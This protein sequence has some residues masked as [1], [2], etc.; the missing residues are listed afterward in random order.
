MYRDLKWKIP[1]ILA[2]VL[3]SV[4]L[5]YPLKEKISLGLDLQ[6]GMHLL[7][8]VTCDVP[9]RSDLRTLYSQDGRDHNYAVPLSQPAGHPRANPRANPRA[10]R[11][12]PA[13]HPRARK[14]TDIR[15]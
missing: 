15:L 9:L 11:G 6:G 8:E 4:L 3:G 12:P 14:V 5:A 10:T 13:G 2:V 7:L 1:L